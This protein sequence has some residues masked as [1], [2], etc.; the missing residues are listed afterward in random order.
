M[1]VDGLIRTH[2]TVRGRVTGYTAYYR[3]LE[4]YPAR[5]TKPEALADLV[6]LIDARCS[7]E[8]ARVKVVCLRG[9]VGIFTYGLKG[10]VD[11]RHIHPGSNSPSLCSGLGTLEEAENSFRH[12]VAQLTWDG[13]LGPCDILPE[14]LQREFRSWC[15]FQL[16]YKI[17]VKKGMTD[18][19]AHSWAC[20]SQNPYIQPHFLNDY[21]LSPEESARIA[22]QQC[23]APATTGQN[24]GSA[25]F[26]YHCD[27]CADRCR[28]SGHFYNAA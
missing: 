15:E 7:D 5:A 23:G 11:S 19:E 16:R 12:H 14:S 8:S 18:V 2:K 28:Q 4:T 1:R 10:Y 21:S 13:Q 6:Q 26:W 22:C 9:H 20:N 17:A 27:G 24:N 3:D 25:P